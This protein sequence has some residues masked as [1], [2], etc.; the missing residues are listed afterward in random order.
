ME[1]LGKP[2]Y[3]SRAVWGGVVAA[4]AG[5]AALFGLQLDEPALV[6]ALTA[7]GGLVGGALAIYGRV[8]ADAPIRRDR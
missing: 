7:V 8:K 6:E 5:V 2:W 1:S 3:E 4:L